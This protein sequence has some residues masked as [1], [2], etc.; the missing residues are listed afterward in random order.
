MKLLF[1]HSLMAPRWLI[2]LCTRRTGLDASNIRRQAECF[3]IWAEK[4]RRKRRRS[5]SVWNY[6]F[7]F[8]HK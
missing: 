5:V 2:G 8:T 7:K 6:P 4:V 3:A 1:A